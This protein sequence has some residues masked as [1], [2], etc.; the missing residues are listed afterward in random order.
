MDFGNILKRQPAKTSITKK[1][2]VEDL[3]ATSG[4]GSINNKTHID[5]DLNIVS[6]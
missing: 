1:V 5:S 6:Y 4:A 3:F 2:K